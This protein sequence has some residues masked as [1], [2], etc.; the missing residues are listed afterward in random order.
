M[1]C[2]LSSPRN[3]A[4]RESKRTSIRLEPFRVAIPAC[5]IRTFYGDIFHSSFEI[6]EAAKASYGLHSND[7]VMKIRQLVALVN[8]KFRGKEKSSLKVG[9]RKTLLV[10]VDS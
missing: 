9:G 4:E 3:G 5:E 10:C 8:R 6:F 1:H 2:A 7:A